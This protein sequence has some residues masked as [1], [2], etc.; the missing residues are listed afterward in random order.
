MIQLLLLS[1][2]LA[3]DAFSVSV[4]F[5]VCHPKSKIIPALR[6]SF[7]TACFQ[8]MMPLIGWFIGKILGNIFIKGS[9]FI[10]FLILF[11]IG[12][13]M[14]IEALIK[15]DKCAPVDISKGKH[16]IIICFATSIDALVA[17]LS[18]GILKT[19]LILSISLI[20][21][22]T[23]A[24][25]FTGVYLGKIFGII[26]GKWAEIAGGMILIGIGINIVIKNLI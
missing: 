8:F 10:A 7:F 1:L 18:L 24:L 4:S 5:G 25:S 6:L 15:K 19:S 21:L 23:L 26:L 9:F 14:I 13:K 2:G 17:G 16:L 20:G 11:A 3:M 12:L 22:V